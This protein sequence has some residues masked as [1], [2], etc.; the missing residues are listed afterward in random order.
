VFE[1]KFFKIRENQQIILN[2]IVLEQ[3]V[4]VQVMGEGDVL[5]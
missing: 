3:P 5:F 1:L 4:Y 2:A